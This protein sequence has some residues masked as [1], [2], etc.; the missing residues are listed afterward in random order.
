MRLRSLGFWTLFRISGFGFRI[1]PAAFLLAIATGATA[2]GQPLALSIT[3]VRF[4]FAAYPGERL[5]GLL[6][7]INVTDEALPVVMEVEDFTPQGEEGRVVVES[8][9]DETSSI[10]D[11]VH[12]DL[13]QFTIFPKQDMAVEFT[14]DIPRDAEPGTRFGT[15]LARTTQEPSGESGPVVVAKVGA[16]VLVDVYGEVRE[17]LSVAGFDV[18][19]FS[20][21]L[22]APFAL[23]FENLGNTR[24]EPRGNIIIRNIFGKV[25][26][27]VPLPERNV[28]PGYTRRIDGAVTEGLLAGRYTATLVA[29]YGRAQQIP[30][31]AVRSFW[32]LDMRRVGLPVLI[33]LGVLA[34]IVWKRRNFREAFRVLRTG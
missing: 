3:P 28:L 5:Q 27:T 13:E 34:F 20:R 8:R 24:V 25:V 31:S 26:S 11:W 9:E 17:E 22:P 2:Q 7:V 16:L 30:I 10:K 15:I 32:F 18:S 33:L 4:E 12:F 14:L 1:L 29:T 23:R 19:R 6:R 21:E